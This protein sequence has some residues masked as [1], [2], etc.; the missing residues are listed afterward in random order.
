MRFYI[1]LIALFTFP[2]WLAGLFGIIATAFGGNPFPLILVLFGA[3]WV[4]AEL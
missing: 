2:L 3:L 1:A 4:I